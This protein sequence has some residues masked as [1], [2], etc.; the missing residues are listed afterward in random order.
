M[1]SRAVVHAQGGTASRSKRY[2]RG[3][4]VRARSDAT[5][6]IEYDDGDS[7]RSLA[8]EHVRPLDSSGGGGGGGE[9]EFEVGTPIEARYGGK[10]KWY[11]GKIKKVNSDGTY[12]IEYDDGDVE[13]RVDA[14]FVRAREPAS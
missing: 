9:A 14:A 12:D 11:E 2:F 8:K 5:Y 1:G 6:D 4:V 3:T 13:H 7:E 10:E